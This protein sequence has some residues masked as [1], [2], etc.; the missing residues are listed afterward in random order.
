M[1]KSCCRASREWWGMFLNLSDVSSQ[2]DDRSQTSTETSPQNVQ[3]GE[4]YR[5]AATK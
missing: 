5:E 3:S 2:E 1:R 4:R